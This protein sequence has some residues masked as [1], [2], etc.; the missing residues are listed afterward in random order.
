MRFSAAMAT[1]AC[2]ATGATAQTAP[3]PVVRPIGAVIGTSVISFGQVQH[4]RALSNG[5]V[6]VNDPGRRQVIMLDSALANPKVV[7]DSGGGASMYGPRA[8]GLI[9]YAGDSTLFVDPVAN[10]FLVIDPAG[11]VARVMSTPS[12]TTANNLTNPTTFGYP[13]FSPGFGIVYRLAMPRPTV[14]R[15]KPGEPE[16][17]RIIDDSALVMTMDVRRRK[18]DTLLRLGTGVT[19]TMKLSAN[20]TNSNSRTPLFPIFD[21][22][23]VMSDG[24]VAVLRGREYRVDIYGGDEGRTRTTGARLPYPWKPTDDAAKQQIVDSINT[25]RRKQFDDMIA[26]MRR[27]ALDTTPKR[28]NGR[29][30]II[31]VDGM[32]VR[33]DE[34]GERSSPTPPP[35]V[36]TTEIPDYIPAVERNPAGFRADADNRLWIRPKPPVGA[37]RGASAGPIYDIVDRTGA[38]VDRVQLPAGRTLAGFGRAGVV[39]LAIRDAGATRIEKRLFK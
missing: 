25:Q 19:L 26:D 38:L 6:L 32:P 2:V 27:Q 20:S 21:D 31:I 37:Q 9:P 4:L 36:L 22:W 3:A 18:V 23:T 39:F 13:A 14:E 33:V 30:R 17:T 35:L 15:P 5:R 10:A 1:L 28:G 11:S 29:E 7:V 8:G 12:G 34:D 16:I 24:A